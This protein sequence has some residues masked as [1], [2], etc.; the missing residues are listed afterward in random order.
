MSKKLISMIDRIYNVDIKGYVLK[1]TL[2]DQ[3]YSLLPYEPVVIDVES[4]R[5]IGVYKKVNAKNIMRKR[6]VLDTST[7]KKIIEDVFGRQNELIIS[8]LLN[9]DGSGHEFNIGTGVHSTFS[10][11]KDLDSG[12]L[13]EHFIRKEIMDSNKQSSY[14]V[15]R[16]THDIIEKID[17]NSNTYTTES[18]D[19]SK[20]SD[21]YMQDIEYI[22]GRSFTAIFFKNFELII[23]KE[24]EDKYNTI[25]INCEYVDEDEELTLINIKKL[26]GTLKEYTI[27]I[28]KQL[29]VISLREYNIE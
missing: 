7:G 1:T 5:Y 14:L 25:S 23:P 6:K 13:D 16:R 26:K 15:S 3:D 11:I 18:V 28:D 12:E 10:T 8:R 2:V 29:N 27:V 21:D 17:E 19:I 4:P 9:L 24:S 20:L 22:E